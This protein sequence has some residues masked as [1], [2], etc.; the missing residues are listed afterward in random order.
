MM[1]P[2]SPQ[3][4]DLGVDQSAQLLLLEEVLLLD[5]VEPDDLDCLTYTPITKKR[6]SLLANLTELCA[7]L[8]S[9]TLVITY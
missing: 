3:Q 6:S 2:Q 5:L 8:P 1:V 9:N 7:P 4:V